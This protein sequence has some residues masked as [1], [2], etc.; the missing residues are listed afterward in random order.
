MKKIFSILLIALLAFGFAM[1]CLADE[2]AGDG[3]SL[4]GYGG[5]VGLTPRTLVVPVRYGKWG[6]SAT[7]IDPSLASG[8]VVTW[9]LNSCDGYTISACTVS[10]DP[11]FAG[12]LISTIQTADSA[13]FRRN[14]RNWGKMAI[15]GWCL[16]KMD[17]VTTKG[18]LLVPS[19]D[20]SDGM[21]S[22]TT[23]DKALNSGTAPLAGVGDLGEWVSLDIGV[24]LKTTSSSGLQPVWLR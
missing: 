18:Q 16:A 9:D 24:A 22:F 20:T 10:N 14:S 21:G 19:A 5:S 4:M 7:R 13:S 3:Y 17:A 12:V 8:D 23:I 1:P 11:N 2:A 15:K 6:T